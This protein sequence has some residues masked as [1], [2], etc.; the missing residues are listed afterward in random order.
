VG[1]HRWF[2]GWSEWQICKRSQ[3]WDHR[4]FYGWSESQGGG[5]GEVGS[6]D[7]VVHSRRADAAGDGEV[8]LVV[9]SASHATEGPRLS[10]GGT[11]EKGAVVKT[12]RAQDC[13][14]ASWERGIRAGRCGGWRRESGSEGGRWGEGG[15]MSV[16][17]EGILRRIQSLLVHVGDG[18]AVHSE[19]RDQGDG[20]GGGTL[21]EVPDIGGGV[22][23]AELL[24]LR[25]VIQ[26][27]LCVKPTVVIAEC[28]TVLNDLHLPHDLP[29]KLRDLIDRNGVHGEG[30]DLVFGIRGRMDAAH[31][32]LTGAVQLIGSGGRCVFAVNI[33]DSV[34]ELSILSAA[35]ARG[36]AI[37]KLISEG[38]Q[39]T[40]VCVGWSVGF[41]AEELAFRHEGGDEGGAEGRR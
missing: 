22:V 3:A 19:T 5:G 18:I 30:K 38:D 36:P 8:Q 39:E 31:K 24:E 16:G 1:H 21:A 12:A 33:A 17:A 35:I 15:R 10:R 23:I 14:A 32:H 13:G 20:T 26:N 11:E 25:I 6:T 27:H 7:R 34:F 2:Y 4:W 29:M 37:T 28:N 41:V 9:T 40:G